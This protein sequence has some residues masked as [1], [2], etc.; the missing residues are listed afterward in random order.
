MLEDRKIRSIIPASG[1]FARYKV[2]DEE[3]VTEDPLV[4]WALLYSHDGYDEEI[5]GMISDGNEI[6][7]AD[8]T[9][10]FLGCRNSGNA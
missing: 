1:W 6:M 7:A 2:V 9:D 5:V 10:N 4:C 3:T 8:L